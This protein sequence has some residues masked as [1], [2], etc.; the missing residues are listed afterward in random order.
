MNPS[1]S[2]FAIIR[3]IVGKDLRE[4]SRDK[5]FMLITVLGLVAY[6]ALYWF[7]PSDVEESISVGIHQ[8]GMDSLF[9]ELEEDGGIEFTLVE[10]RVDL[11]T[12]LGFGDSEPDNKLDIGL[13]FPPDFLSTV[14]AGEVASVSV[15][16]GPE[17]PQEIRSAMSSMVR[18]IAYALA[19]DELPVTRLPEEEIILGQDRAG[20]QVP[21]QDKFR[22]LL[23]FFV[24]I[25]ETMALGAL[26]AAEIQ[27][28]TVT[29]ILVTPAKVSDFLAAKAILGT[30]LAFSQVTLL[31][32]LV[33]GFDNNAPLMIT[34][35]LLGSAL[36]TGFGLLIGSS[37]KDFLNQ[38][39]YS[40]AL[41]I[42]LSIPAFGVLFP[43]AAG[44]FVQL[45]PT[46]GLVDAMVGISIDGA[47]WR[48]V[49]SSLGM[50]AAWVLIAFA[51]GLTLLKRKVQTL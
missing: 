48:D 23:A 49:A 27:S 16:V 34:T 6:V 51:L 17:V 43:G 14:S 42:P 21:I 25:M 18:E 47:G 39:F 12:A 45:L 30:L 7:L 35:L 28:R 19:G 36:V 29:A 22:P 24:L 26:V 37:G 40:M 8:S 4:F 2:R 33:R 15:L 50:L 46:F 10:S 1:V 3:A 11:E 44:P 41:L 20:S 32:V 38:I 5:F 31:M 13:E 9:A